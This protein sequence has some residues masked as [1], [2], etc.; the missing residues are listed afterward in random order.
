MFQAHFSKGGDL[1]VNRNKVID[2]SLKT[3]G[4][5]IA[6]ALLVADVSLFVWGLTYSSRQKAAMQ[7]PEELDKIAEF[8][9]N[10][11]NAGSEGARRSVGQ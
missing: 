10:M 9:K 4:I 6:M 2:E 8:R 3:Y 1:S 5:I 7:T 11:G